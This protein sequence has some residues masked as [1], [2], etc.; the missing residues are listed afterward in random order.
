MPSLSAARLSNQLLRLGKKSK[1]KH[2]CMFL[3][4]VIHVWFDD[5]ALE[6]SQSCTGD[7]ITLQ[8]SLGTI[9][10]EC[11]YSRAERIL[12]RHTD[13]QTGSHEDKYTSSFSFD[14]MPE[15]VHPSMGRLSQ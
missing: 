3:L 7:F 9:G 1:M 2:L 15:S 10:K 5:F 13:R 4:Q 8:D 12:V 11:I 6:D 14:V